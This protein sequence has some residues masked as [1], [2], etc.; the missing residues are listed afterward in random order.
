[1]FAC[2]GGGVR[3]WVGFCLFVVAA[4]GWRMDAAVIVLVGC[5]RH[6]A[7]KGGGVKF[8]IMNKN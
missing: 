1:M 7:G 8:F 3:A 2:V 5:V 6:D 4:G